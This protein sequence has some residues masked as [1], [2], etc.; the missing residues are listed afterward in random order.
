[1]R[2]VALAPARPI[3]SHGKAMHDSLIESQPNYENLIVLV[4]RDGD[5]S[6]FAA[7]FAH[8]APRIKSYLM[9]A[10]SDAGQADEL[11][12]EVM[13]LVWRKAARYDPTQANAATWI[14]AIARNKRIDAFR[15]TRRPELDL[16]DPSLIPEPPRPVDQAIDAAEQAERLSAA[17]KSLP[18]EQSVLLKQAF[19]EDK[20]HS[21]IAAESGL[22]LGTVKS[23]LRLALGRLRMRLGETG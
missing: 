1:M 18:E 17:I 14:F 21:T 11:T 5:R 13:L 19:F 9:R 6:A 15:R 7:L 8:F 22:P 20:S 4:G 10:G 12:Q 3:A 16:Q 23:R 2:A